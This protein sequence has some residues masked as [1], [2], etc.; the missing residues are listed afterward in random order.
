MTTKT[1][2]TKPRRG[3][4]KITQDCVLRR[5]ANYYE[6]KGLDV[7]IDKFELMNDLFSIEHGWDETAQEVTKYLIEKRKEE[8]QRLREE[9]LEEQRAAASRFVVVSKATSDAR[10]I[11]TAEIDKM[12][13]E[14]NSPGNTIAKTIKLGKNNDDE[15]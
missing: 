6:L 9:K 11:G 5:I 8:N 2:S 12:D 15:N 13:V 3:K 10:T 14:V 1:P 7:A 4:L